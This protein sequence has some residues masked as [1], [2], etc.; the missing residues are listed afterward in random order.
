M[1]KR[2]AKR[3]K[4]GVKPTRKRDMSRE[5]RVLKLAQIGIPEAEIAEQLGIKVPFSRRCVTAFRE[6]RGSYIVAGYRAA[7]AAL[8][9]RRT[10]VVLAFLRLR[11][12]W[13]QAT[14]T[15]DPEAVREE[16][17]RAI[18][19]LNERRANADPS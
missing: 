6:G 14:E 7:F 19:L 10:A 3:T 5:D 18:A 4:S 9:E 17:A 11:P 15:E 12:E 16:I 8:K 1:K 2:N 13:A